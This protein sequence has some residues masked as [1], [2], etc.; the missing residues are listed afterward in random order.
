[1]NNQ[2]VIIGRNLHREKILADLNDC[3]I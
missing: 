1:M 3:L 2:L